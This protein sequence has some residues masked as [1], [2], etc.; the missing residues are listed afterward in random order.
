MNAV[1]TRDRIRD[2]AADLFRHQGYH[3]SGVKQIVQGASAPLASLYHFFPGG[4][5]ALGA[6]VVRV[7]GAGYQEL[8]EAVWDA[9][10]D[11]VAGVHA[12]FAGAAAVLES[13]DYE[14]ACP[15]A[16]VALEVASTNETLRIATAEVFDAWVASATARAR[17]G[18]GHEPRSRASCPS[19]S[20][21]DSRAPSCSH[22]PRGR[23][24]RCTPPA[25]CSRPRSI[26][27]SPGDQTGVDRWRNT[28]TWVIRPSVTANT[29]ASSVRRRWS[30]TVAVSASSTHTRSL[31]P[32]R[33]CS[34]IS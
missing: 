9:E 10:P 18:A 4:K 16:T 23:P 26:V 15:I 17:R 29:T 27:R 28:R 2:S 31:S 34:S 14:D 20:S 21:V 1:P 25:R 19:R 33:R 7:S 11:V 3:A 24:S 5:E 22:V 6:E 13:T 32:T 30:P 12:V 8:V